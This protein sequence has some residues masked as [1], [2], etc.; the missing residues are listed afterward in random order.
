[1]KTENKH[2]AESHELM[3][4]A[5]NDFETYTQAIIPA[6]RNLAKKVKSGV[7]DNAKAVTLLYHVATYA[8]KRYARAYFSRTPNPQQY[9]TIFSAANRRLTA[10]D[11]LSQLMDDIR[12]VA[13]A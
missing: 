9:Y 8:A 3:L 12:E 2:T 6:I 5:L 11:L 10:A 1:M 7:F 4:F 13:E